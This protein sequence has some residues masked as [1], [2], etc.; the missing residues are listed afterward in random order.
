MLRLVVVMAQESELLPR[1]WPI[2]PIHTRRFTVEW[3]INSHIHVCS[4]AR[5][6]FLAQNMAQ[7]PRPKEHEP[8]RWHAVNTAQPKTHKQ[9]GPRRNGRGRPD[10]CPPLIDNSE[11]CN[12]TTTQYIHFAMFD[13]ITAELT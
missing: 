11:T 7:I 2:C 1:C 3:L 13:T 4:I 10:Y 12:A 9:F 8:P 6:S 5:K